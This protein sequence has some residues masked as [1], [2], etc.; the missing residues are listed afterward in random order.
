M[1]HSRYSIP[2]SIDS[3]SLLIVHLQSTGGE[4]LPHR[5]FCELKTVLQK[6]RS[7]LGV[8]TDLYSVISS[9]VQGGPIWTK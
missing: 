8:S 6:P 5:L 1:S 2:I 3:W 9:A 4:K 7:L